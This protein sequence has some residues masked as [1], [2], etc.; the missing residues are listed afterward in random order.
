M[1]IRTLLDTDLY[2]FTTSYAYIKL[3]PYA[4]G[5]FSF[6]DR[7]E[8]RYTEEFL[9]TLKAEIENLSRLRLTDEELEYMVRNC[10]FLPRVYWEWLS[11]FRFDPGKIEVYLDEEKHLHLEV[12]DYLYKA[13]LYEVPLLAIVSEIKNRF[14]GNVANL[15]QIIGKL[16]EKVTLS[17]EHRLPFS[18]FGTRRRFSFDV[19][20]AVIGYLND[21][22]RYCT[23]TSNCHFAMKYRMKMMGTH[24]H[25]WFM[26]HGAQFGYKH[27]NY[28]AL[29]NWVNVYD[30]DLGIALSDTYT[31]GIFLTNLSRK[32]AKLFDGVRCDSGDEFDFIDQ[33]T[34]RYR[35]LGVDATTKTIVFSNALDFSKA[36]EIQEYGRGKIRCAFGIGTN[37]TNDTGYKPSNIVMKLSQCKMNVNQE[38]RECIKLSDDAGKHTGSTEE[39]KACLYELKLNRNGKPFTD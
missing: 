13:T 21:T 7:D 32:Q 2:K 15:E 37:L 38:W 27:A 34:A 1:I 36:L 12:T 31:S 30:G 8:T 22:S 28:M 23:G 3:F 4:M 10:R 6:K 18:E 19:Q 39:I 29:E 16:S 25:E 24:P 26:F 35:E 5:T 11:S 14:S 33:L 20:D 17:N 9:A